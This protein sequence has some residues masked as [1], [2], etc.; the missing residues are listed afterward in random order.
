[1][2]IIESS[3]F[4]PNGYVLGQ[5]VEIDSSGAKTW[6][7]SYIAKFIDDPKWK[8]NPNLPKDQEQKAP[9]ILVENGTVEALEI[10]P[11]RQVGGAGFDGSKSINIEA[12]AKEVSA[13]GR[14]AIL[15][16]GAPH[17]SHGEI[18]A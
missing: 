4:K 12:W 18:W 13:S 10:K 3:T 16:F 5:P 11:I 7:N 2:S 8:P 17:N 15:R 1:M 14:V 9:R 6:Y